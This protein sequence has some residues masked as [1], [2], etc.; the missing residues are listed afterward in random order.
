MPMQ[1][2]KTVSTH[3]TVP[4][5]IEVL[6]LLQIAPGGRPSRKSKER[7]LAMLQQ[8]HTDTSDTDASARYL[9]PK[10]TSNPDTSARYLYPAYRHLGH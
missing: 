10:D 9:Y 7:F 3:D 6:F 8:Q 2:K 1:V 4:L 5:I